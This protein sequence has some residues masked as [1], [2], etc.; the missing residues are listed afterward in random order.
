[1]RWDRNKL[2]IGFTPRALGAPSEQGWASTFRGCVVIVV[3]GPHRIINTLMKGSSA[4]LSRLSGYYLRSYIGRILE[5]TAPYLEPLSGFILRIFS[6]FFHLKYYYYCHLFNSLDW[7]LPHRLNTITISEIFNPQ[8]S[9][10]FI[11]N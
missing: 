2:Q 11:N 1:M 4:D 6:F 9:I 10:N 3:T 7:T 5:T 8:L